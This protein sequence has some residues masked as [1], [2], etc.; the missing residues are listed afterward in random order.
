MRRA[1]VYTAAA[2]PSV[3]VLVLVLL[4]LVCVLGL[5]IREQEAEE[6]IERAGM[7]KKLGWGREGGGTGGRKR[8]EKNS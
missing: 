3:L 5:N 8:T 1:F 7:E 4:A 2:F 6:I